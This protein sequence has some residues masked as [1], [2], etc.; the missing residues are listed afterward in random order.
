MPV[1]SFASDRGPLRSSKAFRFTVLNPSIPF[2]ANSQLDFEG[3]EA[4]YCN[5]INR[6]PVMLLFEISETCWPG[7][8][9]E[10]LTLCKI[11]GMSHILLAATDIRVMRYPIEETDVSQTKKNPVLHILLFTLTKVM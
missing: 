5:T 6:K 11:P 7:S 9:T 2:S 10:F 1:F 3:R 4:Q 8:G